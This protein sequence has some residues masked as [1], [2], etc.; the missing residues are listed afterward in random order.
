MQVGNL[1]RINRHSHVVHIVLDG[2]AE[3]P[4]VADVEVR[5]GI[6]WDSLTGLGH[7]QISVCTRWEVGDLQ[8]G[9]RLIWNGLRYKVTET[10]TWD[11]GAG[12]WCFKA[13]AYEVEHA[14]GKHHW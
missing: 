14:D 8:E 2:G 7:V 1:P 10:P 4:V 9:Q 12:V 5:G 6:P 3:H 13:K 11:Q